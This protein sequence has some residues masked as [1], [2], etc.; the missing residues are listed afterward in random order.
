MARCGGAAGLLLAGALAGCGTSGWAHKLERA[1]SSKPAT[2]S[3]D[4]ERYRRKYVGNHDRKALYWLLRHR[5]E[6]GMAYG[7]VCRILGED[8]VHET[9]DNWIKTNGGNYQ[10]GDDCYAFGPDSDGQTLYLVFRDDK[11]VNFDPTEFNVPTHSRAD[12]NE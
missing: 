5:V 11:L 4:E 12:E 6:S 8:G 2:S 10:I 9:R 7:E 1:F 3:A